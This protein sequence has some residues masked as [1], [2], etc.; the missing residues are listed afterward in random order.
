MMKITHATANRSTFPSERPAQNVESV[1]GRR[2][3]FRH[4]HAVNYGF[5]DSRHRRCRLFVGVE[6]EH[7]A[8]GVRAQ[9]RTAAGESR[10]IVLKAITRFIDG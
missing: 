1:A 6:R 8:I 10:P 4:P 7:C 2:N 5:N 9:L 3:R